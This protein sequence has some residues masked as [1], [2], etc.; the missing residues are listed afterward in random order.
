MLTIKAAFI[1]GDEVE[2]M[3]VDVV[4]F[5]G[6]TSSGTLANMPRLVTTVRTGQK[7]QVKLADVGDYF[8]ERPGAPRAGGHASA[9]I[10]RRGL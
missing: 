8:H 9:I 2:N 3:W 7:V 10:E 4:A 6:N 5:R 1:D